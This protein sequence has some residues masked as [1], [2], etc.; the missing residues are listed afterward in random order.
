MKILSDT[1]ENGNEGCILAVIL[2]SGFISTLGI[3]LFSF[4]IPLLSLD[5]K[6]SGAWLGSAFAGY[7]LA[8]LLIA[9]LSGMMADRFGPRLLLLVASLS[10]AMIPFV[11]FIDQSL[12]VLY[13]VQFMMGVVSGLIKPV[14]LAALGAN[15][16]PKNLSKWFAVHAL[17]FNMALFIG[18][19]LGGFLYLKRTIEPILLALSFCMGLTAA[20][21]FIFLPGDIRSQRTDSEDEENLSSNVIDVLFLFIAVAGR[22]LGIGLVVAFYPILLS[23]TL[24]SNGLVV[25]AVFAVP[26][27]MI[28]LG[29]FAMGRFP[30]VKPNPMTVVTGMFVSAIGLFALGSCHEIWQFVLFGSIMGLG[31]A[32]SIPSSMAMASGLAKSQGLVFGSAHFAAGIGFLLGPLLGGM[33]IQNYH[34]VGTA[35][36]AAAVIG[37]CTC[38]PLFFAALRNKFNWNN[39]PVWGAGLCGAVLLMGLGWAYFMTQTDD[40]VVEASGLYHYTDIAMGTIVKLTLKAE[41]R[42]TADDASRKVLAAMRS[43]QRDFDFRNSDGSIGQINRAAGKYWVTPSSRVYDLLQ[44]TLVLS[45][46]TGGVF[47]PTVGALTTSHLYYVLDQTI[48]T[49]KEGLVDYRLVMVEKGLKRVRLK[50]VGMALDMGGI[51]KGTIVDAAVRLLRSLKIKA[52]I[53]EAGGDFYCFGDRDWTVGVRHPR[54][55]DVYRTVTVREKGV[56]GSGDYE[57]YVIIEKDTKT[58]LRHHII[59]PVDMHS[60]DKSIGVTVIAE[61]AER[62]DALAT[63]LFIM[64][65]DKG[66]QFMRNWYPEES[67][68]WFKPDLSVDVTDTF[69]K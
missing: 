20:I 38:I 55:K 51:A 60:A 4:T 49:E 52:G 15:G 65:A 5:E 14:G 26:S 16:R 58:M 27:L 37:A 34:E 21:L 36:Q 7:Y 12:S 2:S 3:G 10:G 17:V 54:A 63:T 66:K 44:R 43:M 6:V 18:P 33:V 28:C 25:G 61:S 53:V 45:A 46:Q 19:L 42:K 22:T 50:K 62:A 59:D 67:A 69:P 35:M 64:G 1:K 23:A 8:K 32:V 30:M 24:G 29:L 47:D 11:Y 40:I 9:P 48:A 57:Q 68:L 56:C 39:G 41:S 13:G 31:A